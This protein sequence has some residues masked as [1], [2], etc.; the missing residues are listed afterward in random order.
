MPAT[1]SKLKCIPNARTFETLQKSRNEAA[2]ATLSTG[3]SSNN[4]DI[5]HLSVKALAHREGIDAER[6]VLMHWDEYDQ[7]DID[8]LHQR[9]GKFANAVTSMVE[10]G[11]LHEKTLAL[12]VISDI[13]LSDAAA[14][15]VDMVLDSDGE[16]KESAQQSLLELCKRWGKASRA[17]KNVP[18][19]RIK[20][21]NRLTQTLMTFDEHRNSALV[22]AW[23]SLVSWEDAVLR[24]VITDPTHAAFSIVTMRFRE[25][26]NESV[27]QLLGGYLW[28]RSVPRRIESA[29]VKR[30]EIQLAYEIEGLLDDD[31]KPTAINRL[32]NLPPLACFQQVSEMADQLDTPQHRR[33]WTLVAASIDDIDVVMQCALKLSK[34][35]SSVC[36][37]AAASM[38]THCKR[39]EK[40]KFVGK[41]QALRMR[42]DDPPNTGELATEIVQWVKSPSTVL[43][44]AAKA[45]FS[46]FTITNLIGEIRHW[47]AQMCKVTAKIVALV[48]TDPTDR[49]RRELQNSVPTARLAA[50]QVTKLIGAGNELIDELM[51]MLDDPKL[52]IRVRVIDLLS[53]LGHESLETML[54]QLLADASTDIQDAAHRAVRRN[55][56]LNAAK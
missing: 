31:N 45:L 21:L 46:D 25:S 26:D 54:P 2:V 14:L 5:R 52:E 56:R 10:L 12:K 23:L 37:R 4:R 50:L 20:M 51:P 27:L 28:R 43:Q 48:E 1:T 49:L 33:L 15:L 36:R 40:D 41:M 11:S 38:I 16:L 34:N 35:E 22:D 42:A 13:E 44:K 9:S 39:P 53:E 47:P 18:S 17:R 19:A 30:T 6:A 55:R 29:L 32:R 7:R 24:S 3:L 8:F